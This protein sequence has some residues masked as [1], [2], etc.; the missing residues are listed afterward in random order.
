LG[1]EEDI[2]PKKDEVRG[3]WRRWQ[4]EELRDVCFSRNI[5]VMMV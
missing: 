5:I 3:E 1:A 2:H 4:N